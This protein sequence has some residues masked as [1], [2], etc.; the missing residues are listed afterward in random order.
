MEL[1]SRF[2]QKLS[3][4]W[5]INKLLISYDFVYLYL[6]N[7]FIIFQAISQSIKLFW[8]EKT[9]PHSSFIFRTQILAKLRQKIG[10][11][12]KVNINYILLFKYSFLLQNS[13]FF[14]RFKLK[15]PFVTDHPV[16][17]RKYL[18]VKSL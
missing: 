2:K 14:I 8:M 11:F 6:T 10:N 12:L 9:L 17:F 18:S 1:S 4:N 15:Y 7:G 13:I 3:E 5:R 16:I